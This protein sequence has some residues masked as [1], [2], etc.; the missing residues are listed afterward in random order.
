[1][2]ETAKELLKLWTVR[3]LDALGESTVMQS[4]LTIGV[5]GAWIY[6]LIQGRPVD[7]TLKYTVGLVTG[8]YFG[9]KSAQQARFLAR[10]VENK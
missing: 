1:M 10:K 9:A 3:T 4:I 6:M 8:F 7:D 2:K 5:I